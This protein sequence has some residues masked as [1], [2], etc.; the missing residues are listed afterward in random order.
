MNMKWVVSIVLAW[1]LSIPAYAGKVDI[2]RDTQKTYDTLGVRVQEAWEDY[3]SPEIPKYDGRATGANLMLTQK[4]SLRMP[5][6]FHIM[7]TTIRGS[8][9]IPGLIYV[10]RESDEVAW[11]IA[12]LEGQW[13][14]TKI[15]IKDPDHPIDVHLD[16]KNPASR[17]NLES[18][19]K[20][21]RPMRQN[22]LKDNGGNCH[23]TVGLFS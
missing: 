8:R 14:V 15:P 4:N 5:R 17:K 23:V 12:K 1:V 7:T 6:V 2:D 22:L 20:Y 13:R 19:L 21:F 10:V 18:M 9:E 3:I 11:G 16:L